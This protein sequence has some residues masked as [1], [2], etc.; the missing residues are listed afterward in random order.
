MWRHPEAEDEK[1]DKGKEDTFLLLQRRL[2]RT[3]PLDTSSPIS[4]ITPEQ[5][6][7]VLKKESGTV[8]QM[9][10]KSHF[11]TYFSVSLDSETPSEFHHMT[12]SLNLSPS[13]PPPQTHTHTHRHT[14]QHKGPE[15]L[16]VRT[17]QVKDIDHCNF[18]KKKMNYFVTWISDSQ[19]L[20]PNWLGRR[21]TAAQ[22][23]HRT[24]RPRIPD[25]LRVLEL[26]TAA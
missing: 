21:E 5:L 22:I 2:L 10:F 25:H 11:C 12:K 7:G 1:D 3:C 19:D 18:S 15:T 13:P 17:S 20:A 16:K 26:W 4:A 8:K 24:G 9:K 23:P 14:K 6:E